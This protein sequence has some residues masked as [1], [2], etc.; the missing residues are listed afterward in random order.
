MDGIESTP[1]KLFIRVE[2]HREIAVKA[3]KDFHS[4]N[5]HFIFK[6][7]E[8]FFYSLIRF[9]FSLPIRDEELKAFELVT[10]QYCNTYTEIYI[11]FELD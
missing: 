10:V 1:W 3:Q 8:S 6:R 9:K 4:M 7:I 2:P 11:E 5:L